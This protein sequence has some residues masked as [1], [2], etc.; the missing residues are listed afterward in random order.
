MLNNVVGQDRA[1]Q[2]LELFGHGYKRRGIIP[3]IGIFGGSGLGKTHLV[4]SWTSEI[5]AKL[6]YINGTS[7]KD[8]LAFRGFFHD[9]V[10][11]QSN[12]YIIFIDECHGLPNKVQDN[13]LSVLEDPAILCTIA[14]KEMGLVR[15]V[16]GIRLIEKGDV[17]REALPKNISF[18]LA[19]TDPARLKESILNRLRKIHLS[20]YTMDDKIQIAMMHLVE[21]GIRSDNVICAALAHRSRS[22]RHLKD[23]LCESFIDIRSLYGEGDDQALSTLDDMLGIDE[24]GANDKDIDYLEYLSENNAVGLDTMA[25]KL[26][27]DK[28]EVLQHIEPF[29]LAKGWVCITGRGRRLTEAG[30]KKILGDDY[31]K[32]TL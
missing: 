30:Y 14:P 3:P 12:Y 5:G 17:M 4:S 31:E 28:Q 20:P 1:K 27:V 19:T 23:E 6:I 2:S 15:C 21:H 10:D 32:S 25:G 8:A 18:V 29:L 11:N 9:A 22:I 26:R 7:I 13:L 16:D 24:D